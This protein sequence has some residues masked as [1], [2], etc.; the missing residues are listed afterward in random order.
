MDIF[1]IG[2]LDEGHIRKQIP[3]SKRRASKRSSIAPGATIPPCRLASR[4]SIQALWSRIEPGP[5]G[6]RLMGLDGYPAPPIPSR[7][8]R[9]PR[10][11]P[12][13]G[14]L[15]DRKRVE[16]TQGIEPRSSRWTGDTLLD[17]PPL[18]QKVPSPEAAGHE[19]VMFGCR[20]SCAI[21]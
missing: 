17:P 18:I 13:R 15:L 3:A 21:S 11:P 7:P 12:R 2:K 8:V 9:K 10:R 14:F 19:L 6:V 4:Q 20:V 16:R 1:A 5:G